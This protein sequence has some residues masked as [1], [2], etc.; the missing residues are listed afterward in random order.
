MNIAKLAVTG[1]ALALAGG[2][3]LGVTDSAF[4]AKKKPVPPTTEKVESAAPNPDVS[5]RDRQLDNRFYRSTHKTHK[6]HK[7][8]TTTSS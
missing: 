3:T 1:M 4:A 7:S 8:T 5:Q 2:L 6:H